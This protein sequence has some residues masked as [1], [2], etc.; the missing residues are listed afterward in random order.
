MKK[1]IYADNNATTALD[2]EVKSHM[3]S[4]MSA[5]LNPSSLHAEGRKAKQLLLEARDTI[6][7]T[8][9]V[10]TES[11]YFTG[12]ATE[13][14]AIAIG[15][16]GSGHIVTSSVEHPAILN[17]TGENVTHVSCEMGSLSLSEIDEAITDATSLLVFSY[18]NSE[19][20][21][22]FPVEQLA[23]LAKSRNIPLVIDAVGAY[24]KTNVVIPDG[25]SAMVFSS[26]K[27]HGPTGVGLL[28]MNGCKPKPLYHGG[29][30]EHAVRSGTE[31][32]VA[33]VGFAK[34]FEKGA[35]APLMEM[36][37][38]RVRFEE[39]LVKQVPGS[40]ILGGKSRVSN[41]SNI[42]FPH[43]DAESIL[44]ML[45]MHGVAA[46]AGSACAAGAKEPSIVLQKMGYSFHEAKHA[47]R[48]SFSRFTT[49]DEIE[50]LLMLCSDCYR[51]CS[52]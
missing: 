10:D 26:H 32:I 28:Y 38:R 14:L 39:E 45:D 11:L 9:G 3:D 6:A 51:S 43:L 41:V 5:P 50:S 22:L 47:V 4:L 34:A 1:R 12:S 8:L 42:Y 18:A 2:P 33:I 36:E 27:I 49:D 7:K 25:V 52:K 20:G 17:N 30:Q 13:A 46:S 37:R 40:K 44:I 15:T 24:G 35:S 23:A 48:F 16:F 19:T 31:N 29:G 21:S